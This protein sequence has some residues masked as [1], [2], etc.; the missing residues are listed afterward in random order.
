MASASKKTTKK[1]T[2]KKVKKTSSPQSKKSTS[3]STTTSAQ[4]TKT[5]WAVPSMVMGIIGLLFVFL[6][7]IGILFSILAIVFYSLYKK[8]HTTQTKPEDS[9]ATAG[10]VMGIIGT[11]IQLLMISIALLGLIF[12]INVTEEMTSDT[13][14]GFVIDSRNSAT[15]EEWR[16]AIVITH[17]ESP[18]EVQRVIAE[19]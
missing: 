7:F 5:N 16:E 14:S 17:D 11:A 2:S 13:E 9:Y 1:S 15:Q 19:G 8:G 4:T 18:Q 12:V 3:K 10:L 6:P